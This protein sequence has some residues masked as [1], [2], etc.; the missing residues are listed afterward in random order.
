M[1]VLFLL[2]TFA[3]M[4]RDLEDK[5]LAGRNSFG[6]QAS[7]RQFIEYETTED[8]R[9][10]FADMIC[11]HEKWMVL[12]GGNNVL[13]TADYDGVILH[14]V[15]DGIEITAQLP[16]RTLVRAQAGV[17][18]DDFVAW[19]VEHELWGAENL[20]LIPGKVGA[21]PIQNIGAYGAEAAGIIRSVEMFCTDTLNTLTLDAAHCG[22]G[23][24]ESIFKHSLKGRA[25]VTAVNFR[26]SRK[27]SPNLGYGALREHVN[28]LGS[29]TLANIRHAVMDIRRSKLPD[30]SVTGNAG[31]FFKNPIVDAALATS[32]KEKFGE[33]PVYATAQEDKVKIAAGWL[34]EK[35]GWKGKSEGAAAV[36]D[37]QAL[38]LVNR[39][40]ATG[41]QILALARHIQD[42]VQA[43]FGIRI[44]TEVNIV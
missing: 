15:S 38:V 6:V 5:S 35:A 41:E 17:E 13:F 29:P 9:T 22:F 43:M 36:H 44:E 19:C 40:G 32:L 14:P 28:G 12:S 31:S 3:D 34:I 4:I 2:S 7:C 10:V 1:A 8:L 42:D 23:Y 27:P 37:R 33:I 21:A 25:I 24:R 39:G 20:S 16:D 11:R 18:W 26:L 30:P